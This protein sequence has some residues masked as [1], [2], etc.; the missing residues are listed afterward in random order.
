MRRRLV[1]SGL[2]LQISLTDRIWPW[3]DLALELPSKMVP[4]FR[5]GD[6]IISGKKSDGVDFGKLTK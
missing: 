2:R 4:K 5:F 3:A 6:D 1:Y